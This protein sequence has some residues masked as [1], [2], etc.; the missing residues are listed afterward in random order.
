V[1]DRQHFTVSFSR[2][3]HTTDYEVNWHASCDAPNTEEDLAFGTS[4]TPGERPLRVGRHGRFRMHRH[5][6]NNWGTTF[7]IHFADR[8]RRKTGKGTFSETS[9][10]NSDPDSVIHCATGP[11]RWCARRR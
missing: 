3:A 9:V 5:F 2:H 10:T 4:S 11:I 8:L 6:T 1:G 7:D